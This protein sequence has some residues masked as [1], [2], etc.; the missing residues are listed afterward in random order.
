MTEPLL[1]KTALGKHAHVAALKDGRVKSDRVKL[2][3]HE[4]EPLPE[5]FRTMVRGGDLDMSEMAVVTHLLAHH[6]GKP[7]TGLAFPLWSR[8]PHTN[9]VC[10]EGSS[11]DGP[12]DLDNNTLGVRAYAQTSG[13]WVRGV[14]QHEYGVDLGTIDWLTMED[15]HLIEYQDPPFCAR[16]VSTKGLRQLM[17]DGKLAAIMGERVVDPTGIRPV[18]PEAEQ[19]A[20]DWIARQ[21]HGAI[22]HI[23]SVKT[24]LLREHPWLAAELGLMFAEARDIALAEGAEAPPEYGLEASRAS[25]QMCLDFSAEQQITP[26]RYM[27]D[28]MFVSEASA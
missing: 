24:E 8:L 9:L 14:L 26:R 3:F 13:V 19:A 21:G 18:I 23:L 15:A 10:A 11:T 25:L 16:N 5:A 12:K 22:N 1:L 28:D 2:E 20:H 17:L 7:I 6:F 4:F 27:V